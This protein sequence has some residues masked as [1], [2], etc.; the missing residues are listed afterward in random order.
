MTGTSESYLGAFA[1]ALGHKDFHLALIATVPLLCGAVFQLF[2]RKLV[3]AVGSRKR[4]VVA[5]VALQAF[6][7]VGLIAIASIGTHAL[8]PLVVV[9]VC[10]WTCGMAVIP[11]WNAWMATLTA[12]VDRGRYFALRSA[13]G[14]V[15]LLLAFAAGGLAMER[16]R[17]H[18]DVVGAFV[19]IAITA[20]V[21]RGLSAFTMSQQTDPGEA[22]SRLPQEAAPALLTRLRAAATSS[23]WGVA[24]FVIAFQL[25]ANVAI[26]FFAPYMLN[27]LHL[28]FVQFMELLASA[29]LVKPL[30]L[31]VWG[32]LGRRVGWRRM[33]VASTLGTAVV[34]A[35]WCFAGSFQQLVCVQILSG[36]SWAGLEL[37]SFQLLLHCSPERHRVSFF[38]LSTSMTACAQ[39]IGSLLG[40]AVLALGAPYPMAFLAS[41]ILRALSVVW[42]VLPASVL[43]RR[44][45]E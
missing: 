37:A 12:T 21:A 5:G 41:S 8:W 2:A 35:G 9:N 18:G 29:I 3:D 26:P 33:L 11:A 40:S 34:A 27:V 7:H 42:L 36:V 10:Y 38:A 22:A 28:D 24:F 19:F 1:V 43:S 31:P 15:G 30:V 17:D 32:R 39:V 23:T 25:G 44:D 16:G 6:T 13:V 4:F 14:Q 20:G 45:S